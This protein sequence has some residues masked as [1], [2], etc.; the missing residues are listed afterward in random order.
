MLHKGGKVCVFTG[1]LP[2]MKDE[3][4]LATVLGHEI[5]HVVARMLTGHPVPSQ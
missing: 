3:D 5:G 2:I 1:I 4:G